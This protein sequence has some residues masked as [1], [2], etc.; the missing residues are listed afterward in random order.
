MSA[1]IAVRDAHG[2]R[3]I[4]GAEVKPPKAM[5]TV[6]IPKAA[7][8]AARKTAKP[9]KKLV[10]ATV[11]NSGKIKAGKPTKRKAV[12]KVRKPKAAKKMRKKGGKR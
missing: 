12:K 10:K 6:V 5:E 1:M 9:A 2:W 11:K 3:E 4:D 8:E 7:K